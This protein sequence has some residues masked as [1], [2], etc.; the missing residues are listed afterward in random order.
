MLKLSQRKEVGEELEAQRLMIDATADLTDGVVNHDTVVGIE[1]WKLI[2]TY[3]FQTV[4]DAE[5]IIVIYHIDEGAI[6]DGDNSLTWVTVDSAE[7]THLS[8][9]KVLHSC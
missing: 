2:Q 5:T 4:F 8:Y 1:F 6:G 9:I 3:P 7:C